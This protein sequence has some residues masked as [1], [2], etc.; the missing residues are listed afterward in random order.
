ME[1]DSG[2]LRTADCRM[3]PVHYHIAHQFERPRQGVQKK[4]KFELGYTGTFTQNLTRPLPPLNVGRNRGINYQK[5]CKIHI[6][7]TLSGGAGR[8]RVPVVFA[9]IH[10]CRELCVE[11]L[12][13]P[14]NISKSF[15]IHSKHTT[16]YAYV[17]VRLRYRCTA[18]QTCVSEQI[19]KFDGQR[20]T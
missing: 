1:N 15:E 3:A 9:A 11:T 5:L 18:S 17:Y 4:K 2:S 8:S 12:L 14:P 20:H 13:Q 16:R 19:D 10:L 6:S 7:A